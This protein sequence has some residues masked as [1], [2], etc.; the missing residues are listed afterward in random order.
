VVLDVGCASGYSTAVLARLAE[1]V[2]AVEVDSVLAARAARSLRQIGIE[3][4]LVIEG[5]LTAGAPSHA[6]FDAILLNGAV[7]QVPQ[8]LL[9]QLR[10]GGR[11]VAVRAEGA[12]GHAQVWRR[13]GKAVDAVAAFDAGAEP[14]PGF[15]RKAEFSL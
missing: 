15:A 2:V 10:D 9:E 8:P 1:A 12:F 14:L 3:N 13:T 7:S 11:L 5:P 6:P 4:A